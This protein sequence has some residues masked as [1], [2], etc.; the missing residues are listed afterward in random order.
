MPTYF[1]H[2][3][4]GDGL[5]VDSAG[6]ELPD[7]G[8]AR[9][10]A[11]KIMGELLES[12]PTGWPQAR[13]TLAIEVANAADQIILEVHAPGDRPSAEDRTMPLTGVGRHEKTVLLSLGPEARMN[14]MM[15]M[16]RHPDD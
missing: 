14:P 8:A 10:E 1:F 3:R 16:P 7:I 9:Q 13:H 2:V 6:S 12:W 11:L 15:F 4:H 5:N